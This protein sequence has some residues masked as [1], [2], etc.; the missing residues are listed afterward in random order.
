MNDRAQVKFLSRYNWKAMLKV[1][2]HLVSKGTDSA[3]SCAV[4]SLHTVI[5]NVPE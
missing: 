2:A 1:E 5:K 4:V 3:R